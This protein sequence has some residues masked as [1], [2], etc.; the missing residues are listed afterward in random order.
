VESVGSLGECEEKRGAPSGR[1]GGADML[2]L[3][4]LDKE[5]GSGRKEVFVERRKINSIQFD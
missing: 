1:M 4:I 2:L 3:L 5:G